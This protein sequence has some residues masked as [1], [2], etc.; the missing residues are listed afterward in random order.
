LSINR[1]VRGA[2]P[3]LKPRAIV[4]WHKEAKD[5]EQQHCVYNKSYSALDG[6]AKESTIKIGDTVLLQQEKKQK[7]MPK[8]HTT[9]YK[10]I[11]RR[12]TTIVA[13]AIK[14]D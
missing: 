13:S 5:N 9:P 2:L 8:F 10:V 6:N 4:N 1:T 11:A 14:L 3:T 7:L 12:G